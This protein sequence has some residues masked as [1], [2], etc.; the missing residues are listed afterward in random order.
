MMEELLNVGKEPKENLLASLAQ[1]AS[2]QENV[3]I[4]ISNPSASNGV[5]YFP[6]DELD[7]DY[8]I[9]F[10][11]NEVNP[12]KPPK[13]KCGECQLILRGD[14]SYEGH[15]NMHKQLRPHQCP[16]CQTKFRCRTALKRHKELRHSKTLLSKE[17]IK[18]TYTCRDCN[19]SFLTSPLFK[20]HQIIVHNQGHKCPFACDLVKGRDSVK[21]H[22]EQ[23]HAEQFVTCA[24]VFLTNGTL[25]IYQCFKCSETYEKLALL[26]NHTKICQSG[27]DQQLQ[28]DILSVETD[29]NMEESTDLFQCKICRRKLLKK[30]L[31]K[32]MELHKR[33]ESREQDETR[34]F[35]C[36]FCRKYI[37][38]F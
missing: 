22:L 23:M 1:V 4:T 16:D 13:W 18:I 34:K 33:K 11:E 30:N 17:D 38:I 10:N 24:E 20:L 37:G 26:E 35:L 6:E 15:M 14:V 36:A 2:T 32:H 25:P 21:Q 27:N 28:E 9:K 31:N 19:N 29:E 8:L 7:E 12:Y 3:N 5:S